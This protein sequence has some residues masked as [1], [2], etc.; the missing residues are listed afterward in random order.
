MRLPLLAVAI[1]LTGL[2][3]GGFYAYRAPAGEPVPAIELRVPRGDDT[4]R[5]RR[6]VSRVRQDATGKNDSG[7]GGG[8]DGGSGA[9]PVP[10]PAAKPAGVLDDDDD[11]HGDDDSGSGDG[12]S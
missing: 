8:S 11:P 9:V 7:G 10:A 1:V 2:L 5:Q 4:E 12:D 3:A 6:P